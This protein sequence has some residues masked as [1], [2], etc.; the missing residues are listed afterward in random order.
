MV[1]YHKH[2]GVLSKGKLKS[3]PVTVVHKDKYAKQCHN[4]LVN[5][6][7]GKKSTATKKPV[8]SKAV[9]KSK[10][11][12][13]LFVDE[14][15]YLRVNLDEHNFKG[16]RLKFSRIENGKKRTIGLQIEK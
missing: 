15:G 1:I 14:E 5:R 12:A 6:T 11:I 3:H 7:K 9:S 13:K 4:L 16:M 2:G 10:L 8:Q